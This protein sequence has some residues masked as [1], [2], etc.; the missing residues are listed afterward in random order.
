MTA[1]EW[2]EMC[3]LFRDYLRLP[4]YPIGVRLFRSGETLP[5]LHVPDPNISL[6]CQLGY[7]A[8][9]NHQIGV[10]RRT[11]V[12]CGLGAACLG[13]IKTPSCMRGEDSVGM[14]VEDHR[15]GYRLHTAVSKL[16]DTQ[17]QYEA[18][19]IA[20]LDII[21]FDPQVIAIYGTPGRIR[22][23]IHA[24]IY[25]E[26]EPISVTT[27]AEAAIGT[28]IAK[29]ILYHRP[30][31]DLPCLGDHKYG[32]AGDVN[33]IFAFPA[34]MVAQIAEGLSK[35]VKMGHGYPSRVAVAGE[36][37]IISEGHRMRPEYLLQ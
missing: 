9:V 28:S 8:R 29:V 32:L 2:K 37:V 7:L 12:G 3:A 19:A 15:A 21:P 4:D 14:Y 30:V 27:A 36:E 17:Q 16:G 31:I 11:D 24:S 26:G 18:I 5:V 10:L 6:I 25:R 20:P 1:N 13:L 23:L 34:S 33:A 22:Q 35:A